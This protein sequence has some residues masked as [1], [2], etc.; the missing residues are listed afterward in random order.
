[1]AEILEATLP[2]TILVNGRPV[3]FETDRVTGKQIK[4]AAGYP[5]TTDLFRKDGNELKLVSNDELVHIHEN[6]MFVD[7]P[8]TPVS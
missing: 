6:E 2:T 1:M 7:L 4:E 5:L 3:L 8:P